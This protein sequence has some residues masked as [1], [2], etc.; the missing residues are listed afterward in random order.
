MSTAPAG[1]LARLEGRAGWLLLAIT[2]LVY[3]PA[4]GAGFVWDDFPLIVDNPLITGGSEAADH[5]RFEMWEPT[6]APGILVGYYRPLFTLSLALDHALVGT[7]PALF[8]AV[9]LAWHLVAVGLLYRLARRLGA[10]AAAAAVG[11]GVFAL[12]PAQVETVAWVS[13][14]S[15]LLA[16]NALFGTLLLVGNSGPPRLAHIVAATGVAL[17]GML[18]KETAV[19]APVALAM[20]TATLGRRVSARALAGPVVAVVWW[21]AIRASAGVDFPT[22]AT[23]ERL[24]AALAPALAFYARALLW[25]VGLIPGTHLDWPEPVPWGFLVL[26]GLL[27]VGLVFGG[28]RR[29][30]G[31]LGLGAVWLAPSL[32][33]VGVVGLVGDR[34]LYLPLAGLG[35]AVAVAVDRTAPAVRAAAGA[36]PLSLGVSTL[37]TVPPWADDLSLWLA[38]VKRHPQPATWAALGDALQRRGQLD[39]AAEWFRK[40]TQPPKPNQGICFRLTLLQLERDDLAGVVAE[41]ERG[42]AAGC[43][44]SPELLAPLALAYAVLGRW[45]EAE[46]TANEVDA[47]PTGKAVVVRVAAAARRGDLQPLFDEGGNRVEALAPQVAW[48]LERAGEVEAAQRVRDAAF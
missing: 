47:D 20:W 31:A 35:L 15:D 24:S 8:H 3:A 25:P 37:V 1:T 18:S 22:S 7:N 16:A 6:P 17:A 14:R 44:P 48:V 32:G 10:S 23:P 42:L 19:T 28:G 33:A 34:Y 13:A 9:S 11:A 5:F 45:D 43:D 40:A 29:A 39:A 30:L 36:V 38:A 46:S 12:H 41:G 21:W 4:L 26:A 27:L 2:A